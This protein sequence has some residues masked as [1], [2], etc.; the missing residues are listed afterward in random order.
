MARAGMG[1]TVDHLAEA[2]RVN[3][4]TVLRFEAGEDV[5]PETAE[6]MRSALV[7]AGVVFSDDRGRVSVAVPRVG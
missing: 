5:R 3:R 2:S 7:A 1:W 4:R 6:A